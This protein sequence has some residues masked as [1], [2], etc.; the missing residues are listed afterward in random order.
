MRAHNHRMETEVRYCTTKDGVRI[1][2]T[3]SGSGPPLVFLEEPMSSHAQLNWANPFLRRYF[4]EMARHNTFVKFDQR[5]TGLSDR[6][7]E[8]ALDGFVRDLEAVVDRLQLT[9]F[10]LNGTQNSTPTAIAYAARHPERVRRLA[11]TNGFAR[12]SDVMDTPASKAW[13]SAAAVDWEMATEAM[14][15]LVFGPGREESRVWG[16][17]IRA[18][19]T[20]DYFADLEAFSRIDASRFLEQLTMPVLVLRH[21]GIRYITDDMTRELASRI[22]D[23]RLVTVEG[24]WADDPEGIGRR[25]ADFI[26][27]GGAP[28]TA[29]V[30]LTPPPSGVRTVLF[31][32]I[33]GH[34]E[35]MQ[36]LGDARGRDVLREHERLV[37]SS[38]EQHGGTEIKTDG[39]SFMVSFGSVA[40][41]TACAIELQRAFAARNATA[42]EP[43]RLRMGLNAG[44]PIDEKGDLFGA[45]VI[46]ASRIAAQ[47]GAGEILVPDTI[48]GLLSGKGFV[49]GD[50]GEFVPKGFDDA[51]RLYEVR[52]QS[53]ESA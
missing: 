25:I 49:F 34:T 41:A 21:T 9:S 13:L 8:P 45:T 43:L 32:D 10:G 15:S 4:G 39:D 38:I 7:F 30:P 31:T 27:E 40:A 42:A 11:I 35:M 3:V 47:A 26:N 14:G 6:A 29:A 37:R 22:P 33:V 5:G 16:A 51:V 50:R 23:A 52:W 48:R 44:E 46:L 17:L 19:V 2:Y 18:S 12:T 24:L 53:E 36:R 1:A 20:P 28:E